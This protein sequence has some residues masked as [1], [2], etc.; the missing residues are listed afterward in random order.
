MLILN[1][2][3]G[4][5]IMIDNQIEIKILGKIGSVRSVLMHQNTS[6]LFAAN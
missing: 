5:S 4:E 6:K 3:T 2:N 1:R